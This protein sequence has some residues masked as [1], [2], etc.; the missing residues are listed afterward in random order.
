MPKLHSL[1]GSQATENKRNIIYIFLGNQESSHLRA[2]NLNTICRSL[3][4]HKGG[5]HRT[6][7]RIRITR[8]KKHTKAFYFE[9]WH[10]AE[11]KPH[12]GQTEAALTPAV[13]MTSHFQFLP[14]L[15]A[16]SPSTQSFS[17]S[18]SYAAVESLM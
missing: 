15:L 1:C 2:R 17:S 10:V 5:L 18:I 11:L 13:V 3:N 16:S 12:P 14:S 8:L 4:Q 6:G 7:L 9:D